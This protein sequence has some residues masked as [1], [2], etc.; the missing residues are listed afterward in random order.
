MSETKPITIQVRRGT[1]AQWASS[2]RVLRSGEFGLNETLKQI[3]LGDGTTPFADLDYLPTQDWIIDLIAAIPE[4]NSDAITAE[5]LQNG[6]LSSAVILAKVSELIAEIPESNS[7]VI[8][9]GFLQNG[10]LSNAYLSANNAAAI[11]AAVPPL[12]TAAT[13]KLP[14]GLV[15]PDLVNT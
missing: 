10:E 11:A 3:K 13:S 15:A 14:T 12:I 2:N 5:F 7:D 6:E 4:S 1:D 8:T 9:A